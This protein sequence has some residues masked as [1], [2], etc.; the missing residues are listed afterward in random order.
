MF[1]EIHLFC[2]KKPWK[3]IHIHINYP[4]EIL[5]MVVSWFAIVY[6]HFIVEISTLRIGFI[7]DKRA[8][9]IGWINTFASGGLRSGFNNDTWWSNGRRVCPAKSW[10][11]KPAEIEESTRNPPKNCKFTVEPAKN[12]FIDQQELI[13]DRRQIGMYPKVK[14]VMGIFVGLVVGVKTS[15]W[16]CLWAGQQWHV[17]RMMVVHIGRKVSTM[18]TMWQTQQ[19]S[20]ANLTIWLALE[21]NEIRVS[22]WMFHI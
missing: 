15:E 2:L 16:G 5:S 6:L 21:T 18:S 10:A 9:K 19:S 3:F 11:E 12:N 13:D 8:A 22:H 20:I 14:G 7:S 17:A 1:F 4:F